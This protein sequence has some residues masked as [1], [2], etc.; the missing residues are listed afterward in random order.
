MAY[1]DG[2]PFVISALREKRSAGAGQSIE[3]RLQLD[4]KARGSQY[5]YHYDAKHGNGDCCEYKI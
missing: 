5:Q 2:R 1:P 4:K 3:L